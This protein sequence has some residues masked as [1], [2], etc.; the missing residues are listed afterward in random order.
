MAGSENV[1]EYRNNA[2]CRSDNV[3][4]DALE[5]I[6][7]FPLRTLSDQIIPEDVEV[8]CS[9]DDEEE[10]LMVEVYQ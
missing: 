4:T 5:F 2:S 1:L 9:G 7:R 3:K 6:G 8:F 10:D